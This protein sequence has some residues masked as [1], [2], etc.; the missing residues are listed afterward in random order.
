V[1]ISPQ[2]GHEWM[3]VTF[4]VSEVVLYVEREGQDMW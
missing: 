3:T 4:S 1:K 2:K